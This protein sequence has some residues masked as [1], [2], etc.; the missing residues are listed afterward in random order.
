MFSTT[1]VSYSSA[2]QCANIIVFWIEEHCL[3]VK[4]L[5]INRYNI[6]WV[7]LLIKA[8]LNVPQLVTTDA[9]LRLQIF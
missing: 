2:K 5:S 7:F 1:F 6:I 9:L 3:K 8:L 4:F